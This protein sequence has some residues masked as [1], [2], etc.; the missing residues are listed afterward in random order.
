MVLA[1]LRDVR[2]GNRSTR[3]NEKS[4]TEIK[5]I[6]LCWGC[7]GEW[8]PLSSLAKLR[9]GGVEDRS[10][11]PALFTCFGERL[12]T[13]DHT[14]LVLIGGL[15]IVPAINEGHDMTVL[16]SIEALHIKHGKRTELLEVAGDL[17]AYNCHPENI[18]DSP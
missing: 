17:V 12:G 6:S 18:A 1:K 8:Q 3:A 16:C 4:N 10:Y 15:P 7:A 5:I 11:S 14:E 13:F 2:N 9:Q